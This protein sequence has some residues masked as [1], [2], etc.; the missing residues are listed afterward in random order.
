MQYEYDP[1]KYATNLAKHGLALEQG[2]PLLTEVDTLLLNTTR[3]EDGEARFKA[4][5]ML[6][7]RAPIIAIPADIEDPDDFIVDEAN[8]LAALVMRDVRRLRNRLGISQADFAKRYQLPLRSLHD[9]EQGRRIPTG[10]TLS[11]LTVIARE[12]DV[13]ADALAQRN[14]A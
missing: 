7:N 2:I 12:P 1:A 10:A 6:G 8:L 5:G 11:Y 14:A 3:P 9:W 4:I 13:I